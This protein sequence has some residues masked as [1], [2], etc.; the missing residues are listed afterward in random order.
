MSQ[1][2]S[3]TN[4]IPNRESNSQPNCEDHRD[5]GHTLIAPERFAKKLNGAAWAA[6]AG[7]ISTSASRQ[8]RIEMSGSDSFMFASLAEELGRRCDFRLWRQAYEFELA[9]CFLVSSRHGTVMCRA[10]R[11]NES[12]AQEKGR[13]SGASRGLFG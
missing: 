9:L 2:N 3:R 4:G 10:A 12:P 13:V 6:G 7:R 8:G 5:I 11:Q 1:G